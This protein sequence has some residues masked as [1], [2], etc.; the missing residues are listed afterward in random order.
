VTST[1]A[2]VGSVGTI[3]GLTN[4][5]TY[6]LQVA[7]TNVMGISAFSSPSSP[8]TPIYRPPTTPGA[9]T[10]GTVTPGDASVTVTWT[11]PPD[12]GSPITGFYVQPFLA[13]VASGSA[14][15]VP[16]TGTT[17]FTVTGLTNGK[18]Y[19]FKVQAQNAV[20]TGAYSAASSAVTPA[21][22]P[23][24]PVIGK[25]TASGRSATVKWSPPK[26]TGGSPVTGYAIT[27][28]MVDAAGNLLSTSALPVQPA[29]A[30]SLK[31]TLVPGRY[32]FTVQAINAA[33]S[34][35]ASA[36]SNVVTVR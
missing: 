21:A 24:A 7:A 19:T 16:G 15:F 4:G 9:P 33:G 26:V 10:I 14:R 2:A 27:A 3:T 5:T 25:A 13:G 32:M 36:R 22:A 1:L 6:T 35:T 17:G 18:A 29:S 34:S 23:G 30:R 11:A 20:G 8:V 31:V 28:L 12:G